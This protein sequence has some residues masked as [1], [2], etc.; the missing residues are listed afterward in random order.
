MPN[1]SGFELLSIVRK[2]FPQIGVIAVSAEFVPAGAPGP[3]LADVFIA[4]GQSP[5]EMFLQI[6][7]L[8]EQAPIRPSGKNSELAAV[9]LPRS[10]GEYIV[11]TCPYC[12]RTSPTSQPSDDEVAHVECPHCTR[13]VT[14]RMVPHGPLHRN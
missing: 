8:L 5:A 3:I 2:R 10:K 1:M 9:W 13:M 14:F 7:S 4:K 11:V 6:T 12:L